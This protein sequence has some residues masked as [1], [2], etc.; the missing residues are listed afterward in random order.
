MDIAIMAGSDRV[1]TPI[2]TVTKCD[3][4]GILWRM[5]KEFR[6]TTWDDKLQRDLWTIVRLAI[7]EDLAPWAIGQP[8]PWW[9][10]TWR[11]GRPWWRGSRASWRGCPAWK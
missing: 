9:R 6:Q 1:V 3:P 11:V 4:R 7:D 2:H 10:R 8:G 5:A